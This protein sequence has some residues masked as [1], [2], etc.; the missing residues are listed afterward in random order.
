MIRSGLGLPVSCLGFALL[1]AGPARS[2]ST[3]EL[4]T[5]RAAYN[6][7]DNGDYAKAVNLSPEGTSSNRQRAHSLR[8]PL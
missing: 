6:A 3:D 5:A 2:M 7:A 4:S 8:A 1:W